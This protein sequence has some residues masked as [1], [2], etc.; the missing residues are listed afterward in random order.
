MCFLV[1]LSI[2]GN[3]SLV[4]LKNSPEYFTRGTALVFIPSMR[5]LLR[6]LVSRSLVL[7]SIL[8]LFVLSSPHIWWCP[9]Q[10]FPNI[11]KFPFLWEFWF[12]SWFFSSIPSVISCFLLFIISIAHFSKPNSIPTFSLNILTTCI[13]VSNSFKKFWLT[14]WLLLLFVLLSI[15]V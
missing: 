9:L 2:S 15:W 11:C 4:H 3:S 8:Y 13:R 6:S 12:F 10:T 1:L 14:V 5:F 7:R